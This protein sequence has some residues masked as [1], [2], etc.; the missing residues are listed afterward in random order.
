MEVIMANQYQPK[1][2]IFQKFRASFSNPDFY[3]Q[4]YQEPLKKAIR[5]VVFFT[6]LI[7]LVMG[8]FVSFE[9]QK[10]FVHLDTF[11]QDERFPDIIISDGKLQLTA[12]NQID[13]R[14]EKG[15]FHAIL[16]ASG[17][18]NYTDLSGF[19]FGIFINE[20]FAAYQNNFSEPFVIKFA[21]TYPV[22]IDKSLF[23]SILGQSKILSYV[24]LFLFF[25]LRMLLKYFLEA[26]ILY[27]ILSFSIPGIVLESAKIKKKQ[28]LSVI[29]YAMSVSALASELF[30]LMKVQSDFLYYAS[31][32]LFYFIALKLSRTGIKTVLLYRLGEKISEDENDI[33][34]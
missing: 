32:I 12:E 16:D 21:G 9:I 25:F 33:W 24:F 2:N 20:D 10:L 1:K 3:I 27:A 11:L 23:R 34:F 14:S 29:L 19:R 15:D 4:V 30:H 6:A 13:F 28:I 5:Y 26:L 18:R 17:E 7:T 22:Q 31:T 8:V